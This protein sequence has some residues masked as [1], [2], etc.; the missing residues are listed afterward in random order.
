M[1]EYHHR[2]SIVMYADEKQAYIG[3]VCMHVSISECA[4]VC[5]CVISYALKYMCM[6]SVHC[7]INALI[8]RRVC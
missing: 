8:L 7:T 2:F 6:Y 4:C 5:V 3:Y 1:P